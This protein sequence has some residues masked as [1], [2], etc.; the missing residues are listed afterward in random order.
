VKKLFY[1]Q[2]I[3]TRLFIYFTG[4]AVIIML[5]LWILQIAILGPNYRNSKKAS[6]ISIAQNIESLINNE[7]YTVDSI[8][9]TIDKLSFENK[10]EVL[11]Y[12][13]KNE[14]YL[15]S[16][17]SFLT[18][19][20]INK[21]PLAIDETQLNQDDPKI[22]PIQFE[23]LDIEM[24][25]Y[26]DVLNDG[27]YVLLLFTSFDPIDSTTIILTRQLIFVTVIIL[28]LATLLS[29]IFSRKL[30]KPIDNIASSAKNIAYGN[31]D[32]EKIETGGFSELNQL[33]QALSYANKEIS[34]VQNL[35]REL[36]A[37]TSHDLRTPLTMI[38]AYAEMVRDLS[39]DNPQKREEHLNVIINESD[40]LSLLVGDLLELSK[41]ESG[42]HELNISNISI[43]DCIQ[44]TLSKLDLLCE[45][46]N[47]V[48]DFNYTDYYIV[49][50]DRFRIMQVLYN[51]ISNAVA[52]IGEDKTVIVKL[53]DINN[54][55]CRVEITDHG[56]GIPKDE[57]PDIWERYYRTSESHKR[58]QI[59]TGLGLSIVKNILTAHNASFGVFS[60]LGKGT[61]F[62]FDLNI[63]NIKEAEN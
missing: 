32:F 36:I 28:V 23:D 58:S 47:Y 22:Y 9:R 59:G 55:S 13:T 54:D 52:H 39:G 44:E 51:L 50:A 12:E 53:F 4:F 31:Y 25:I 8:K 38:K 19:I 56:V 14:R 42:K 5:L 11:I 10:T 16:S 41:L 46:E 34:Q 21:V 6:L 62:Y 60:T 49:S 7:D 15:Y 35:R 48:F 27:K 20:Y 61:T 18:S 17:V 57:L 33:S 24:Y 1:N 3:K 2:S 26:S 37:N 43:V 40:R 30:S 45:K 29:F 63:I